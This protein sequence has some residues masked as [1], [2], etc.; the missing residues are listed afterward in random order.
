MKGLLMKDF[1]LMKNQ[2]KIL[3][4]IFV[5]NA[6]FGIFADGNSSF[7]TAYFTIFLALFTTSTISY[8]E[9]D[10]GYLF[11]FTLPISRK[12]YVTGKYVF[13]ILSVLLAWCFGMAVGT[14][15]FLRTTPN[16]SL[17]DWFISGTLYIAVGVIFLSFTIPVRLKFESEKARYA[18]LIAIIAMLVIYTLIMGGIEYLPESWTEN[19][20]AFFNGLGD[21]GIWICVMTA[22]L[23]ILI[24]SYL[25]SRRI[26]EKK[27][28]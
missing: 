15:D 27:E 11:L 4:A 18:N 1:Q 17:T 24:I 3:I 5:V 14:A 25:C 7:L 19:A 21:M 16:E 13:G 10:S 6:A 20:A 22:A 26:M 28:F 8:D 2:G 12:G 9:Y 23:V